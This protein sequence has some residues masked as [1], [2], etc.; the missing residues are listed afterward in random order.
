MTISSVPDIFQSIICAKTNLA[1][2]IKT[3]KVYGDVPRCYPI[4]LALINNILECSHHGSKW[5]D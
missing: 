1:K 3:E 2:K 5:S 4:W